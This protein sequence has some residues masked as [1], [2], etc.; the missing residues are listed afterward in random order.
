M[1]STIRSNLFLIYKL[2]PQSKFDMQQS[3]KKI[4][5]GCKNQLKIVHTRRQ[6]LNKINVTSYKCPTHS[7]TVGITCR[8]HYVSHNVLICHTKHCH[9]V[10]QTAGVEKGTRAIKRQEKRFCFHSFSTLDLARC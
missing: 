9:F 4:K 7:R 2:L 6:I 8:I 5:Y 3:C 10:T 1:I